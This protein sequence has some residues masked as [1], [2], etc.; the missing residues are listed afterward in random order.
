MNTKEELLKRSMQLWDDWQ[1]FNQYTKHDDCTLRIHIIINEKNEIYCPIFV[2]FIDNAIIVSVYDENPVP[3]EFIKIKEKIQ[4]KIEKEKNP[5]TTTNRE[6]ISFKKT[7]VKIFGY[8]F[9]QLTL[10]S[11]VLINKTISF[12]CLLIEFP[13]E[14]IVT[15]QEIE[16][17]WKKIISY[18]QN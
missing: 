7:I 12:P 3:E 18:I 17:I 1:I 6:N 13:N 15:D 11:K 16:K 14:R 4:K 10:N 2:Q 8:P 9:L 5:Q